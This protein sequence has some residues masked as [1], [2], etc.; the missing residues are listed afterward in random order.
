M[1]G[2]CHSPCLLPLLLLRP[3]E[4]EEMSNSQCERN[5]G[6]SSGR[7]TFLWRISTLCAHP[8]FIDDLVLPF[9]T[10]WYLLKWRAHRS[11]R[12]VRSS[13]PQYRVIWSGRTER[14]SNCIYLF[15]TEQCSI[16]G[17][18][19]DYFFVTSAYSSNTTVFILVILLSCVV[20]VWH[21]LKASSWKC[22]LTLQKVG[23]HWFREVGKGHTAKQLLLGQ[24]LLSDWKKNVIPGWL[25]AWYCSWKALISIYWWPDESLTAIMRQTERGSLH[26][27]AGVANLVPAGTA[28]PAVTISVARK[29]VLK[30]DL[31]TNY[32]CLKFD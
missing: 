2:S 27:R 30:I 24:V 5:Q 28:S 32:H 14:I 10:S 12:S 3:K 22:C 19:N 1:Q 21:T 4:V 11:Y 6:S 8:L 7:D 31:I 13:G 18:K 17:K 26:S 23:A 9:S 20:F 15:E 29:P 16:S 25:P